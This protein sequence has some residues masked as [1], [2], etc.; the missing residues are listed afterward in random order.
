M[1]GGARGLLLCCLTPKGFRNTSDL[2]P[3]PT[4]LLSGWRIPAMKQEGVGRVGLP[5]P[6]SMKSGTLRLQPHRWLMTWAMAFILASSQVLSIA[7][8]KQSRGSNSHFLRRRQPGR[9]EGGDR[10]VASPPPTPV[11]PTST[12]SL[13]TAL[14]PSC[15]ILGICESLKVKMS[16]SMS[17]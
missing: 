16:W 2:L 8:A 10:T 15:L 14:L 12:A 5:P 13:R 4:A 17:H 9:G 3:V 6:F 11:C 1:R 7:K